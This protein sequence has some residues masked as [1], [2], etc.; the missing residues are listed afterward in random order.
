MKPKVIAQK[1]TSEQKSNLIILSVFVAI[2]IVLSIKV[3]VSQ[4]FPT[5]PA[6]ASHTSR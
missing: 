5:S 6:I 3:S 2:A 4:A 1:I